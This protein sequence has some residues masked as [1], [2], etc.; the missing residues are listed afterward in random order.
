MMYEGLVLYIKEMDGTRYQR[1]CSVRPLSASELI[2]QNYMST[3]SSLHQSE[4]KDML[5]T[6]MGSVTASTGDA[7]DACKFGG[8]SLT[9]LIR[10]IRIGRCVDC[11]QAFCATEV[12]DGYGI[13]SERSCTALETD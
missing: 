8:V 13:T 6:L 3:I 10:S 2:E 12:A 9:V 1:L 5:M 7:N 4:M 11:A